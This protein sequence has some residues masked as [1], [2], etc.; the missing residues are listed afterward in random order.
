[1]DVGWHTVGTQLRLVAWV[2]HALKSVSPEIP[3]S[4]WVVAGH[5]CPP[6][7]V[8]QPIRVPERTLWPFCQSQ[9]GW[10]TAGVSG[11][12][13]HLGI[14]TGLG[15]RTARAGGQALRGQD[16]HQEGCRGAAPGRAAGTGHWSQEP[17]LQAQ[18]GLGLK[19]G[20]ALWVLGPR[21]CPSCSVDPRVDLCRPRVPGCRSVNFSLALERP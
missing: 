10:R 8:T 12:G 1:M 2:Q 11:T 20:P 21:L 17:G 9:P 4:L 14:Q 3:A 18:Q 7:V 15:C 5:R 16:T 19:A 13:G 6:L